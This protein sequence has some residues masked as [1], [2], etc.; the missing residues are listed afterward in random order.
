[1]LSRYTHMYVCTY[2]F[3]VNEYYNASR[4]RVVVVLL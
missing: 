3:T 1:M 2:V 4:M